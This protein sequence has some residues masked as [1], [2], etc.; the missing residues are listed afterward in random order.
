MTRSPVPIA[1]ADHWLAGAAIDGAAVLFVIGLGD[2]QILGALERRG[3]SGRVV[4]LEPSG[5]SP[6]ASSDRVSIV[7]GPAYAG[8]EQVFMSI[9]PDAENPVIVGDPAVMRT[10][11]PEWLQ[12]ARRVVHAWYG[13]RA[14]QHAKRQHAGRYLL[15]SLRNIPALTVEGDVASLVGAFTGV[16]AVVVAAGP[17]LDENLR[18]LSATRERVLLIAV[19]TA[20]RPLLAAGVHPDLV[21]AVDPSE[22]NA[23]HLVDLPECPNTY[24]VAEGSLDP[25]AV[26]QFSR[27][28]L[29]FRV[30]DH[31]PWPWLRGHGLDR[32]QLRAWG[33]VL[34]TAFDLAL[35]MGCD[36]IIFAGAD[37]AFTGG[38]PYARG[39]TFEE[40]WRRA[41]AWGCSIEESWAQR[42]AAWPETFEGGANGALVRT[43]PHLRSFR[44]WIVTES[45]KALGRTVVNATGA[46]ILVGEGVRQATLAQ[47]L[48]DLRP[49]GPFVPRTIA[50]LLR[51]GITRTG[52]RQ[53]VLVPG[54]VRREWMAFAGVPADAID[55]ALQPA[56][57]VVPAV[58][59]AS[60]TEATR[61]DVP[62]GDGHGTP[63]PG[64]LD[65]QSVVATP[66]LDADYLAELARVWSIRLHAFTSP[67]QDLLA[68]LRAATRDLA[69][70]GALVIV[71]DVGIA[72]G[73]QVRQAVDALLCERLDL[74]LEY[75]RF[76]DS[77]SRLTV[78]RGE[79]SCHTP[80]AREPDLV[81]WDAAHQAVA[82]RLV[83]I[84]ASRLR[85][86]SVVDIG[87]GA[88]HWLTALAA[89]GV[90]DVLGVAARTTALG[91]VPDLGRRFDVCLCLEVA[92]WLPPDE[93]DS[94]IA[95]CVR[96][97]DVVVFASRPPGT[98]GSS[99]YERPLQHWAAAFWRHGYVL[100]DDLRQ[101]ADHRS[102]VPPSVF[103]CLVTFRR[104]FSPV[105][106][107]DPSAAG[108]ALRA[109]VLASAARL[110]DLYTQRIWWAVRAAE[111]EAAAAT[112]DRPQARLTTWPIPRSRLLAASDSTRVF[113][114]RT[115]AAR[116]YLTHQGGAVHVFEDQRRLAEVASVAALADTAGGGW[117]RW[118]DEIHIV[119][120]DG[121]DPRSGR[122]HYRL[123]LPS[124]VAWAE[125][126]PSSDV[127]RFG[128]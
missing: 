38:R 65:P 98:P 12:A 14:N 88:G 41:E 40:E 94:M 27:R 90:T 108:L 74:W 23:S 105:Q 69:A 128:L 35:T 16:P 25:E 61:G 115:E 67:D 120:S 104:R 93:Q 109:M 52:A 113:R 29:F 80:A 19:D 47:S 54:D 102:N 68:E 107:A 15:N 62:Q 122:H 106:A 6:R 9:E 72:A 1:D 79:A 101:A 17:T 60:L 71:D 112:Q 116:W 75:R 55:A 126:A 44:D 21:V 48:H 91:A 81:K 70:N 4:A 99:P 10:R 124:H 11:R 123:V 77:A 3:W 46:G 36:P 37:L 13:A 85:P 20:L 39:T 53:V 89:H 31:H 51:A 76:S 34:T 22:A 42:L 119:A 111:R 59:P 127:L 45:G 66:N 28:T 87:C 78:I 100:D 57:P 121:S 114:F 5:S 7:T 110:H 50:G 125:S 96:A 58:A 33:S 73:A 103:D 8:L 86:R 32:H 92:Q 30:A 84:I 56:R 82:T 2:G 63:G 24:L 97:S 95:A 64:S 26:R 83:P 18:D 117:T 49:L 118:R 43:A